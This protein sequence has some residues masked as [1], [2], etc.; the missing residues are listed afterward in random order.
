MDWNE[1]KSLKLTLVSTRVVLG[2]CIAFGAVALP[3]WKW[4]LRAY[5]PGLAR[6][7][8]SFILTTYITLVPAIAALLFLIRLLKN[9]RAGGIFIMENVRLL[10]CISWC[11]AAACLIMVVSAFYYPPFAVMAGAFGLMALL[12]NAVKNCFGHAVEMKDEL[13][14]TV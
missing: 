13:D 9:L 2:L 10:R 5:R 12:L 7:A 8:P 3:G 1:E 6:L 4:F 11:C 14:L